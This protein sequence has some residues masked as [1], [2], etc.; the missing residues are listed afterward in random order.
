[1][2]AMLRV[3]NVRA[4]GDAETNVVEVLNKS[5]VLKYTDTA[6]IFPRTEQIRN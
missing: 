5:S 2:D 6:H 4:R 1:M 3:S